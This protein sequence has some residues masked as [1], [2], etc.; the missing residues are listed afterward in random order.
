MQ[1]DQLGFTSER[2]STMSNI[3]IAQSVANLMIDAI[4][5]KASILEL[6][7]LV[8][9]FVACVLIIS[10]AFSALVAISNNI[11]TKAGRNH[12]TQQRIDNHWN[13]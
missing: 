2:S 9:L 3:N 13:K 12:T 10:T 1:T 7:L 4:E 5:G 8:T 6:L 11:A